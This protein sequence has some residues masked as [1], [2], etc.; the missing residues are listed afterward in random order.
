MN[1]HAE[2]IEKF[3]ASFESVAE[4]M[5][6]D[7]I[8]DPVGWQ[9]AS[10]PANDYGRKPWRPRRERT[11]ASE[12]QPLYAKLPARFPPLYEELV[13]SYRWADVDLQTFTLR[14]TA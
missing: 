13:L 9:L 2:L 8:L 5:V 10:G 12:L 4:E 6:A 3:V 7:E 14:S 11:N 1:D